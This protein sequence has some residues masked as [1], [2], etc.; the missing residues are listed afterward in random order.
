MHARLYSLCEL[1]AER[2]SIMVRPRGGDWLMDARYY[3]AQ[4]RRSYA[5]FPAHPSRGQ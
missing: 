1:S 5:G 3:P 2:I 4:N